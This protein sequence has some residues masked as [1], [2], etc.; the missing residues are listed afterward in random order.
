MII[1]IQVIQECSSLHDDYII[2]LSD[3]LRAYGSTI[4]CSLFPDLPSS[5]ILTCE[6]YS[7]LLRHF[8]HARRSS[9]N[10]RFGFA[11][12]KLFGGNLRVHR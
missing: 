12:E 8:F 6:K 1:E 3:A 4:V 5:F 11:S 2:F 7:I 10:G 9:R